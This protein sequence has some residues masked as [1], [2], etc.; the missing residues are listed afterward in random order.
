MDED[1]V[2]APLEVDVAI[3]GGGLVGASLALA[4]AQLSL[5]VALIEA[6]AVGAQ[7]QPSFDDRTT[8]LSNGSRRIFEGLGVWPLIERDATPIH[9]IHVSDKGRFGFARI[10]AKGQGLEAL[11]HV[12]VNRVMGAALWSRLRQEAVEIIAPARVTGMALAGHRQR[13]ECEEGAPVIEAKLAVAADGARSAMRAAAGVEA[14]TWDYEQVALVT[15]VF[16]QRFHNHTAYERFTPSGPIALLPMS[17]GRL[18]LIWTLAPERAQEAAGLSD[19]E[20]LA[21][22]QAEFGFRLGR[23]TRVGLRH[24]YP[25]ALTRSSEHVA[26]R[27]AIVGN[28]A[29]SLHPI[30]GQGFNLGLRDAASLAEVLAD[31][32]ARGGRDFDPGDGLWLEHYREWREDDRSNIVRFTDGLV[33]LFLQPFGPAK[34]L[35]DAGMLAFDLMPAAKDALSQLSLGAAGKIPRLARGAP[36]VWKNAP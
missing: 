16:T 18:G 8:A 21:R 15:N 3:A 19:A 14:S 33:R 36:L 11:G 7:D 28:A 26:P 31:G 34:F 17:E 6:T 20:F 32:R 25:L 35:R 12:V 29:Q 27:L 1:G 24:L 2:S 30:A 4:L 22:L 5:R 9:R 23:F 10:D 13:I